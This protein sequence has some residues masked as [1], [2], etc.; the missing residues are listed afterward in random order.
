MDGN[1]T[2]IIVTALVCFTLIA[3]AAIVSGSQKGG[4]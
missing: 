1:W 4:K 2:A 3:I